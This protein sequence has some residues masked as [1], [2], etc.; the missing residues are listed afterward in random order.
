MSLRLRLLLLIAAINVGVLLLVVWLGLRTAEA[1]EPVGPRAL[2]EA[3]RI[4]QAEDMAETRPW[5]AVRWATRMRR[6]GSEFERYGPTGNLDEIKARE[7]DLLRRLEMRDA[8]LRYDRD[9]LTRINLSPK[10]EWRAYHVAF[11]DQAHWEALEGLRRIFIVLCVGTLLLIAGTYFVLRRLVLVPLERLAQASRAVAA[12]AAPPA[13]PRPHGDD[14][15]STLVDDFNRMASEVHEYQAHLEERVLDALRRAKA[16]ENRLVIA[17][18]L[19]ATG[20]LAAGFAHEIN[21][22]LG[23]VLNALRKLRDGDLAPARRQEYF[24]LAADGLQRI[25]TI[26]E[27]ILH[28]TPQRR[29]PA[30]VDVADVCRRAVELARHQAERRGIR[31]EV[32]ASKAVPGVVGDS[33]E[34]TQAVLN[35]VLNAVDA[36]PEDGGGTIRVG[37]RAEDDEAVLEVADDGCG[38]DEQTVRQCVDL[39]FSTKPEGEGTGLGLAIVQHIVTDHGGTLDIDSRRGE[40]TT[41]RIRLPRTA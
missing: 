22:P 39:F 27:R 29:E 20:T 40:G 34:L 10:A 8:G 4:A 15:M 30:D 14:E 9:G 13:V 16:A 2:A 25:R 33:Q 21:N 17:Q 18:R 19:A 6:G 1:L 35:L 38:M 24:E 3:M 23:G 36:I 26:V 32:A 41:V 12:G 11:S 37:V 31:L 5:R 7:Q 28:F